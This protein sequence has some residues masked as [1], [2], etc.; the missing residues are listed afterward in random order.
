V[1]LYTK[2][3]YRMTSISRPITYSQWATLSLFGPCPLRHQ[4]NTFVSWSITNNGMDVGLTY[5]LLGL[6]GNVYRFRPQNPHQ[7]VPRPAHSLTAIQCL[8]YRGLAGLNNLNP[9]FVAKP[10][11]IIPLGGRSNPLQSIRPRNWPPA[12]F[13]IIQTLRL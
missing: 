8:N 12:L 7:H 6:F 1:Q 5:V 13:D 3:K 4:Y 9:Q 11:E 10:A 2:S